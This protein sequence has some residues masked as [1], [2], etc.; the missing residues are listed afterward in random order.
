MK[1]WIEHHM[2]PKPCAWAGFYGWCLLG[3]Y[4]SSSENLWPKDRLLS[5]SRMQ[6]D[7]QQF[8]AFFFQ[9]AGFRRL[10]VIGPRKGRRKDA[11]K[12]SDFVCIRQKFAK[13]SLM[14]RRLS[15]ERKSSQAMGTLC[16]GT[17]PYTIGFQKQDDFYL[18]SIQGFAPQSAHH[19]SKKNVKLADFTG[20]QT[21]RKRKRD[22]EDA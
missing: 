1:Q 2:D 7:S 3:V 19:Q 22:S 11:A 13:V 20:Y 21:L 9:R 4:D 16:S 14:G 18:S 8:V 17:H 15:F 10:V 12:I 5:L 6:E